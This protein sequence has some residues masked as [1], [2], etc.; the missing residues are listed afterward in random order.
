MLFFTY[1]LALR[2]T[3]QE[4][5]KTRLNQTLPSPLHSIFIFNVEIMK[6][7]DQTVSSGIIQPTT[8]PETS[9]EAKLAQFFENA[10]VKISMMS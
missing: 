6:A 9:F 5:T 10:K 4:M 1:S 7:G 8:V 2:I 3:A